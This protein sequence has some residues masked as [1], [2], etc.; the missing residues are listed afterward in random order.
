LAGI[1][2]CIPINIVGSTVQ[3]LYTDGIIEFRTIIL[4][5]PVQVLAG[6]IKFAKMIILDSPVQVLAGNL[7]I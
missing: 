1:I 5:S 4:G 6:I 2:K 3:V 7:E